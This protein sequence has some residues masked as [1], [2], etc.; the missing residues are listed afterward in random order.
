MHTSVMIKTESDKKSSSESFQRRV[1][2]N[3]FLGTDSSEELFMPAS[4]TG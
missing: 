4:N 1:T 3:L 2:A